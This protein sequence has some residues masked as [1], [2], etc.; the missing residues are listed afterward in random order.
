MWSPSVCSITLAW[1]C[2]QHTAPI[3]ADLSVTNINRGG[4][5]VVCDKHKPW[6]FWSGR[7]DPQSP[8]PAFSLWHRTHWFLEI[9]SSSQRKPR[10]FRSWY[11]RRALSEMNVHLYSAHAGSI[12]C[13]WKWIK[14]NIL[15]EERKTHLQKRATLEGQFFS[16]KHSITASRLPGPGLSFQCV[17]WWKNLR[18]GAKLPSEKASGLFFEPFMQ[19]KKK[20]PT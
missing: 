3:C 1:N 10:V 17:S 9:E 7:S 12:D 8:T 19:K 2:G 11:E 18:L 15:A 14:T 6:R 13:R 16:I 4:S 20:K 5:W